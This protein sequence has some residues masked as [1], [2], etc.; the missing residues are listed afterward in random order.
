M[1]TSRPNWRL[2]VVFCC[3]LLGSPP[4][5]AHADLLLQIEEISRQIA[6]HGENPDLYLKRG[7]LYWRHGGWSASDKDFQKVRELAPGHPLVDWF[8]ARLL[9]DT[10]QPGKADAL[11]SRFLRQNP[12]HG[13]AYR[14]RAVARWD[15]NQPLLSARDYQSAISNSERPSPSLFRSLILSL[16]AAGRDH[17]AEAM[18]EINNGLNRFSRELSL[19][20]LGVDLALARSDPQLA[21]QLMA[22]L[23]QG[24][25][26]LPQWQF[27][28]AVWYC[29]DGDTNA[30][31]R[32]FSTLLANAQDREQQRAG[33][34]EPPMEIISKLNSDTKVE[35]CS[36]AMWEL[37]LRQHP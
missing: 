22:R 30:A 18:A 25:S 27:R 7:A 32:S 36:N 31:T 20:G 11:L 19:L 10:D 14:D 4:L 37:L 12:E 34:W 26:D 1:D 28:K 16:L 8:E 13:T 2:M 29:L 24:L 21:F 33:T 6:Q 23:P 5:F 35:T 15:L 9:I 17:A 3:S